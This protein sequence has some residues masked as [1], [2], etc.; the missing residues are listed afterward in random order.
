MIRFN[1]FAC[2]T[3]YVACL[4][5]ESARAQETEREV[6][7]INL[8]ASEAQLYELAKG[9]SKSTMVDGKG[10]EAYES[11]L[12]SDFSR[13]SARGKVMS[14]QQIVDSIRQWWET[15]NRMKTS[16]E[17]L[18]SLKVVGGTAVLRKSVNEHYVD[19]QGNETGSFSGYIT[20]VWLKES[21][22]WQLLA[23]TIEQSDPQ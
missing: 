22:R 23:A 15:G 7:G 21:D 6:D 3:I 5:L 14:K 16:D 10:W 12:H 4:F 8:S 9:F 17:K 18:I 19:S 2:G 1:L 11:Y 20:H 13:W